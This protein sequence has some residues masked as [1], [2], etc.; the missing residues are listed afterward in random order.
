MATRAQNFRADEQRKR[1]H[2]TPKPA[3]PKGPSDPKHT[4]TRNVT[5]R[6]AKNAGT[7]LE[8]STTGR[9]SRKSTR[10]SLNHGRPDQALQR[11]ARVATHTPKA[12]AFRAQV[13]RH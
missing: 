11:A 8:D 5:K 7:A 13:A 1:Q 10:A 2:P 12:R 6:A 3:K 4:A 9:P